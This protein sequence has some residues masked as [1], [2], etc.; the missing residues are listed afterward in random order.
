MDKSSSLTNL[1]TNLEKVIVKKDGITYELST[2]R[3]IID[4][5][6]LILPLSKE[7]E[8]NSESSGGL[9]NSKQN[10]VFQINDFLFL[11]L[12]WFIKLTESI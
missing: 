5:L 1:K 2:E 4:L 7:I 3:K 12:M 10:F 9:K 6:N 11:I 8:S